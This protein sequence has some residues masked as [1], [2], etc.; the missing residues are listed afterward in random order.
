MNYR[1]A[2]NYFVL[3]A[4]GTEKMACADFFRNK[5]LAKTAIEYLGLTGK[6]EVREVQ[7]FWKF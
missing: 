7:V 1:D 4:P 6:A 2:G 3:V 5:Q